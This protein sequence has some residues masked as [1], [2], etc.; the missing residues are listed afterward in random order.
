M[1]FNHEIA[2][3]RRKVAALERRLLVL[4]A[5]VKAANRPARQES[6]L[7]SAKGGRKGSESAGR[8]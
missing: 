5:A 7:P 4:E 3:L 1:D 8:G 6:G 2:D